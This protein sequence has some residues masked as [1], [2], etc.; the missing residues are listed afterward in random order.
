MRSEIESAAPAVARVYDIINCGPR[1]RFVANGKLIHNSGGD[2]MNLQNLPRGGALRRALGVPEGKVLVAC[3]SS[4]IEARLVAWVAG[5]HD[6]VQQFADK[7]DVYCEFASEVYGRPIAKSDK[8]ER[9][10]G[11]TAVLGLG[12]GMGAEKFRRTL[13][14][15]AG[16]I[17]VSLSSDEA[18]RVVQLYREKNFKIAQFWQ[19]CGHALT[20]IHQGS[21]FNLSEALPSLVTGHEIIYLPNKMMIRYPLLHR[22][23]DGYCYAN[24]SKL[25]REAI[26]ARITG[27]EPPH[28]KFTRIYGG[29]CLAGDT[30][31]LTDQG[32]VELRAVT[33]AHKIWDGIEWVSHSGLTY[34]GKKHTTIVSGVRMTP[35]HKVLT[36]QGWRDAS[37]CE[38]LHRADFRMPDGSEVCGGEWAAFSV[39]VSVY[40]PDR[41]DTRRDRRS[42]VRTQWRK[43]FVRLYARREEPD[44]RYG[45][46]SCILGLALYAGQ[47]SPTNTPSVAQLWSAWGQ[48]VCT[49]G[50]I[51]HG[52]LG[53]HGADVQT[54]TDL[55]PQGQRRGL[56]P[57]QLSLGN[58]QGA[59]SQPTRC[60]T[61]GRVSSTADNKHTEVNTLLSV[62][63]E[64]VYD[65][66]NA[67]PRSRF[68]V[69]GS[70]GP[71][72]VHNC[73]E[74]IVQALARIVVADQ[75]VAIGRRYKVILQVHDEVVIVCDE[76]EAPVAQAFMEQVMSTPPQWAADLPVTCEAGSGPNYGECK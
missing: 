20:H 24:T 32:W 65:L 5:Q 62:E 10:V 23:S 9:H 45:E 6:L 7:R 16:G 52:F 69:R 66:R 46:A 48:G 35:D 47:V 64:P 67:G 8:L 53:G 34:Q 41:R 17:K 3:D 31:V 14:I 73:T 33:R 49:M 42:E 59:G 72:I 71:F 36:N 57:R 1:N 19:R 11:K 58:P 37:S 50:G 26:K 4:Q 56:H 51:I 68:V 43:S 2:K 22:R 18:E 13:E 30:E 54:R 12:Y 40:L 29:K 15:G 38:G 63:A 44:T 76:S 28:D 60:Y 70:S 74:N 61:S 55:R 21:E 27:A 39:G 25:Y 75:M